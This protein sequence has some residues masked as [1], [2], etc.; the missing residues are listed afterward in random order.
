MTYLEGFVLA[1]P[2][3]NKEI[4]RKHASEAWPVFAGF[5]ARRM[6]EGWGDEVPDG[7]VTDFKRAVQAKPDE[8]VLFSWFEFASKEARD[9]H[10]RKMTAD[11]RMQ[12]MGQIPFDGTRMIL[13][14]FIPMVEKGP[15]GKMGYVDGYLLAVPRANKEAYR[16][17]AE[18]ASTVFIDHGAT[19]VVEAWEDDVPDGKITD[20]RRAV[21]A[22]AEEAIVF[23]WVEW[24][25]KEARAAGW[26]KLMEDER[27][28]Y[29]P[30]SIP[31]DGQRMIYGTFTPLVDDRA[32]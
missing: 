14:G 32:A 18:K 25:S 2:T 15:G 13:G 11:P 23:S 29:D 8:T 24:P 10:N 9:E 12:E 26:P 30:S 3:A 1:V 4:Y 17:M 27:M 5:G 7:T 19:R 28:K 16:D 6:V 22:T 31:F 21:N 20:F